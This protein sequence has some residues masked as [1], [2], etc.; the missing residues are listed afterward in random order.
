MPTVEQIGPL[1]SH[2]CRLIPLIFPRISPAGVCGGR[3]PLQDTLV[4][5][6]RATMADDGRHTLCPRGD[7]ALRLGW[8]I[9]KVR[10]HPFE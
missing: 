3:R 4:L 5:V 9:L 1:Q 7:K 6:V 10:L 8:R 2:G